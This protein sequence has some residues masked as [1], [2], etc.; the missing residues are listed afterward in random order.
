MTLALLGYL[1][2]EYQRLRGLKGQAEA[3]APRGGWAKARTTVLL[4]QVR[5]EAVRA[6]VRW[7]GQRLRSRS[8]RH[9]L[10]QALRRAA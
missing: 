9:R 3:E 8:G 10:R 6:D 1:A 2:L 4:Q 5:R 7:I